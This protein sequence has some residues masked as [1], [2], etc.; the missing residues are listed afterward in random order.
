MISLYSP[1]Q[2]KIATFFAGPLA[3]AYLLHQ[4]FKGIGKNTLAKQTLWG[5]I[6]LSVVVILL[7]PYLP[8]K[9][10]STVIPM[11][12]LVPVALL[13][14]KQYLSKDEI[15]ASE[16]FY[17]ESNWRV[18]FVCICSIL[19]FYSL[20]FTVVKLNRDSNS[21][22]EQ[23][24]DNIN[25]AELTLDPTLF[26]HTQAI[27]DPDGAGVIWD[28]YV[29]DNRVNDFIQTPKPE[30]QKF[31]VQ[32]LGKSFLQNITDY[33]VYIIVRFKNQQN[34]IVTKVV[35]SPTVVRSLWLPK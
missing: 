31:A 17:F 22:A 27:K 2:I 14:Q 12:Y 34:N 30:L 21:I 8:E 3:A 1:K 6:L 29:P 28:F 15:T 32:L 18:A 35:L 20:A 25:K 16:H 23:L 13:L 24:S 26:T 5:S 9:M 10:P 33:D 11:L 19:V 4:A 7:L